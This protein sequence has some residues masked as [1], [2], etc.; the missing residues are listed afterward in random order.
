MQGFEIKIIWRTCNPS[1]F[2][3]VLI[4][5]ALWRYFKILLNYKNYQNHC[6]RRHHKSDDYS[7]VTSTRTKVDDGVTGSGESQDGRGHVLQ[8]MTF[9]RDS[10][11]R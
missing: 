3:W 10:I 4:L 1:H 2:K 11:G 5:L 8:L 6:G 7:K 9:L